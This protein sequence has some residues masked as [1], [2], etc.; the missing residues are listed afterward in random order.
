MWKLV[1][2]TS[3]QHQPTFMF[4]ET[5]RNIKFFHTEQYI[6]QFTIDIVGDIEKHT[7][8]KNMGEYKYTRCQWLW[9]WKYKL[10]HTTKKRKKKL[11]FK[12]KMEEKISQKIEMPFN[13]TIKTSQKKKRKEI[14]PEKLMKLLKR[15]GNYRS[16]QRNH[17]LQPLIS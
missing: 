3:G 15:V 9:K 13:F 1:Q 11:R 7:K 12:I 2:P 5:R 10:L 4:L 8:F 6:A 16:I 17:L 14:Y